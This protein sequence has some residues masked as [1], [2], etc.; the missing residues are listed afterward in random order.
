MRR[1]PSGPGC[2][3]PLSGRRR[4]RRRPRASRR[5]DAR[6]RARATPVQDQSFASTH[7]STRRS[8]R[9]STRLQLLLDCDA[10]RRVLEPPVR[11]QRPRAYGRRLP[12]PDPPRRDIDLAVPVRAD[13]RGSCLCRSEGRADEP[14]RHDPRRRG[15]EVRPLDRARPLCPPWSRPS[16]RASSTRGDD[17]GMTVHAREGLCGGKTRRHRPRSRRRQRADPRQRFADL[18]RS[19]SGHGR[20]RSGRYRSPSGRGHWKCHRLDR[21]H[22]PT[23]EPGARWEARN[24]RTRTPA[25]TSPRRRPDTR[26]PSSHFPCS[27]LRATPGQAHTVARVFL[28]QD[29]TSE[30]ATPTMEARTAKMLV[31][32]TPASDV[33]T[34][35]YDETVR[36]LK[37]SGDWLPEGS[38]TTSRSVRTVI[39]GSARSGTRASSSTRSASV[40]CR[41]RRLLG[42]SFRASPSCSRSTTSSGAK[43]EPERAGGPGLR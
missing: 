13:P 6:A 1:Q 40:S 28:A 36:R 37:E 7:R 16:R 23:S 20:T 30:S 26:H 2:R 31:R 34:D 39:S 12:W 27:S 24:R 21:R 25:P 35:Q 41:C 18:G 4:R 42:S 33:T 5:R 22:R 15:R 17:P 38:S 14:A 19:P 43:T 3:S 11:D 29:T 10:P 8:P 32:F 9:P